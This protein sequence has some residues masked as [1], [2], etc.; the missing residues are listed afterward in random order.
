MSITI[1]EGMTEFN[2]IE[3][4]DI[5][6]M[7]PNW[8]L[9]RTEKLLPTLQFMQGA[10]WKLFELQADDMGDAEWNILTYYKPKTWK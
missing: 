9:V 2:P 5:L 6:A 7:Q 10:G 8:C 3:D 1:E 4:I